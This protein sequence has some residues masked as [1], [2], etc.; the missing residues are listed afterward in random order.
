LDR[1]CAEVQVKFATP[2]DLEVIYRAEDKNMVEIARDEK[3]ADNEVL[4]FAPRGVHPQGA[5]VRE[6]DRLLYKEQGTEPHVPTPL[7]RLSCPP[8]EW[9]SQIMSCCNLM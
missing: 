3:V 1:L 9:G 4:Y 8:T 6:T 5:D 7:E 2:S